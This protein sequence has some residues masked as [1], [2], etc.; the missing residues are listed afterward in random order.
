MAF[1]TTQ[2]RLRMSGW[3][4]RLSGFAVVIILV[5]GILHR[6]FGL[7]TP[8]ALNLFALGFIAAGAAALVAAAALWR[9][10]Q[11]GY[12]GTGSALVAIAVAIVLFMWPV[13]LLPAVQQL[14]SIHDVT[15]D[16]AQPPVFEEI[17]KRRGPG[18]NP[19]EYAGGEVAEKQKAAYP[20]LRTLRVQREGVETTALVAQA[21]RKLHMEIVREEAPDRSNGGVGY[22]EAVDRT[23]VLGF[24]DDVVV[25]V[26]SVRGGAL[27]DVRSASRYGEHDLGANAERVRKILAALV[28]R[29]QATVPK[30]ES[31]RGRS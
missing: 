3:A 10:W 13:S 25:R 17:A 28:E 7:A 9:I 11:R 15:T 20:D 16:T 24:Y 19:V 2:R 4:L 12:R 8:V 27:V 14:P 5:G 18:A 29:I 21:L 26:A 30:K 1:S 23:L 22:V 31:R 6:L